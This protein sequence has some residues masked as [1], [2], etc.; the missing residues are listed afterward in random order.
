MFSPLKNVGGFDIHPTLFA[1]IDYMTILI[2]YNY[3]KVAFNGQDKSHSPSNFLDHS[4][5]FDKKNPHYSF[6]HAV[7]L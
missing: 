6:S 4:P 1:Q 3:Y 5:C 2:C 7:C